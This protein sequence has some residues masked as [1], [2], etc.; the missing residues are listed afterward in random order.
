MKLLTK[1]DRNKLPKLYANEEIPTDEQVAKIKFFHPLSRWTWFAFEGEPVL[2]DNGTEVDFKFFGWVIG[3][4]KEWGYFL[5]SELTSVKVKGLGMERDLH[6]SPRK[7]DKLR[8][9]VDYI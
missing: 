8:E 7:F 3:C 1:A 4:E 6:F 5:L 2:D 9:G